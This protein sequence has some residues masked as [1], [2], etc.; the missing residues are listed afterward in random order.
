MRAIS[1][2]GDTAWSREDRF[3]ALTAELAKWRER[4]T[5][6]SHNIEMACDALRNGEEV[7]LTDSRGSV[8]VVTKE[9]S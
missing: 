2:P 9:K 3:D 8:V 6:L 7:S 4:A 5:Q 1:T